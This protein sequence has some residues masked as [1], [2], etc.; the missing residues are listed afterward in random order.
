V[1]WTGCIPDL[2]VVERH[3]PVSSKSVSCREHGGHCNALLPAK[4]ATRAEDE[5]KVWLELLRNPATW[6]FMD[7][8]PN[9]GRS[10]VSPAKSSYLPVHTTCFYSHDAENKTALMNL[11]YM[12]SGFAHL[13][14]S[15]F[16]VFGHLISCQETGS[17]VEPEHK[18]NFYP[19]R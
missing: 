1:A 5:V 19:I 15:I 2:V 9:L 18:I 4:L 6:F 12:P 16:P 11:I 7:M 17:I 8:F 3:M 13:R 14:R 10:A